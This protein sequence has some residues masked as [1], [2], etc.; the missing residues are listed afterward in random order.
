MTADPTE[1]SLSNRTLVTVSDALWRRRAVLGTQ[2]RRLSAG[3]Q[4]LLVLA[5]LRKGETYTYSR[6]QVLDRNDQ[7][8]PSHPRSLD[9]LIALAPTPQEDMTVVAGKAFVVLDSTGFRL[10][11]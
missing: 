10:T 8:V 2:R 1:I 6:H 3:R 9:V 5:H 11:E 4:A 7:G